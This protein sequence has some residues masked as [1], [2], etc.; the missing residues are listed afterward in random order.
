MNAD[1]ETL[2]THLRL[3]LARWP[4]I[5]PAVEGIV[6]RVARASARL[7]KVAATSLREVGMTRAEFQVLCALRDG[8]R[9]HGSLCQELGVSTGT[10]TNRLDKL[11][12]A[13][14]LSRSRDPAD[15]RGVL[16]Q[17]TASGTKRLDR[18]IGVGATRERELLSSLSDRDKAQLNRLLAKLLA[19]LDQDLG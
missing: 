13:G 7:E 11:E 6:A 9:S 14:V 2:D 1:E 10:M 16:L 19:A 8:P 17:L 15:R 18:Y 3:A 5:D 4:E 12:G